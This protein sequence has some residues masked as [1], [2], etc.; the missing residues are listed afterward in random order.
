MAWFDQGGPHVQKRVLHAAAD[1]TFR[2]AVHE[3]NTNALVAHVRAA[4][5]GEMTLANVHPFIAG[6]YAFAHNGTIP[7]FDTIGPRMAVETPDWLM[8]QR[9]GATD[10]ELCF[11]WLLGE[12][13]KR[14]PSAMLHRA[15]AQLLAEVVVRGVRRLLEWCDAIDAPPPTLNMVISDGRVLVAVRCGRTLYSLHRET[16]QGCEL[17]GRCHCP[18]CLARAK[19]TPPTHLHSTSVP[20]RAFAVASEPLTEEE[21]TEVEDGTLIC[22]DEGLHPQRLTI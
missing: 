14:C 7:E 5:V 18:I 20:C 17:C 16:L 3:V 19:P 11:L 21:W 1:P 4:T 12:L 10:S 22:V 2:V 9:L 15:P 13:E 6:R 8:R